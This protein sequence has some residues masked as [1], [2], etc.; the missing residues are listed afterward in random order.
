MGTGGCLAIANATA[1]S[2]G[3]EHILQAAK[4]DAFHKSF[5]YAGWDEVGTLV[6]M[7]PIDMDE[8]GLNGGFIRK[9]R[10]ALEEMSL[11]GT[12]ARS[13]KSCST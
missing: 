7:V 8:I 13:I 10:K 2:S 3:L 9:F 5:I 1:T 4:L 11:L 12:E 6:D